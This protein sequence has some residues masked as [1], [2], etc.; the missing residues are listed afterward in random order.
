VAA[1]EVP[2]S[3]M[4]VAVGGGYVWVSSVRT[5]PGVV[6]RVDPRTNRVVG[7]PI[8]VGPGPNEV[9]YG[10]RAVWVENTSPASLTRIDPRSLR[11][12]TV[13][14]AD[15]LAFNS[16]VF[17]DVAAGAG[18]IWRVANNLLEKVGVSGVA[19]TLIGIPGAQLV[20]ARGST[21]WVL[22]VPQPTARLWR[23]DA[24][25]GRIIGRPMRIAAGVALVASSRSIW[26][27]EEAR[28]SLTRVAR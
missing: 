11:P 28:A 20:A 7:R 6:S 17:G 23:I 24:R 27:A 12:S 13:V 3:A 14:G 26:V 10:D 19:L 8:R 22:S 18:G 4:G 1:A 21:V 2:G 9:E 5:G 15:A 16:S 25:S